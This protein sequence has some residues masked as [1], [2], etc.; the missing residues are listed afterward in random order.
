MPQKPQ[1]ADRD[2]PLP[3]LDHVVIML[4][5]EAHRALLHHD[6]VRGELGRFKIKS[7]TS[8]LA[9]TYTS[10]GLAGINTLMEFFHV[11]APPLPALVGAIVLSYPRPGSLERVRQHLAKQV[12]GDLGYE[13]VRRTVNEGEEPRPWYHLLRPD[14]GES[15]PFILM[16][17]EVTRDYFAHLGAAADASGELSRRS[18]LRAALGGEHQP[19]H[20][21]EDVDEVTVHLEP[22]RAARLS[23]ILA[24]LGFSEQPVADDR[25]FVGPDVALRITTGGDLEEGIVA[26][27]L[28]L[29]RPKKAPFSYGFGETAK[30]DFTA[31]G[32]ARWTFAPPPPLP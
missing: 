17:A 14:F 6:L 10:A 24:A 8:S 26:V 31:D 21:F 29:Q 13:L 11:A 19:H 5:D 32:T 15:S 23:E 22:G 18:Y 3:Y 30:L 25:L 2:L 27:R 16:I 9:S 20:F 1:P 12:A 4:D 28:S 7:A